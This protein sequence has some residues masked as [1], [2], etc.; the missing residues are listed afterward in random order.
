MTPNKVMEQ[1]DAKRPNTY[2]EEDKM[3]WINDVDGMV[4]KLVM[5]TDEIEKY[6]F[7]EDGDRELLIPFPFDG[8]YEFY[9]EAMMDFNN[10]EYSN[11]NNSLAMF[12]TQFEEYRKA[13]IR[14]HMPKSAGHF[15]M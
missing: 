12:S 2:T 1:V 3:K 5:K 7:P 11:Y 6:K 10:R 14:E 15:K 9:V 8:V 4:Q 13:Y